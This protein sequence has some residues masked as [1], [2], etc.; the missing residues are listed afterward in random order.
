MNLINVEQWKGMG[1]PH[2]RSTTVEGPN[3]IGDFSM[4]KDKMMV[5]EPKFHFYRSI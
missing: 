2:H 1:K 4:Y 3:E 5:N